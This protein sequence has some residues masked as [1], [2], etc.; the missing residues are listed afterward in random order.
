MRVSRSIHQQ[1]H[2]RW[3]HALGLVTGLIIISEFV[4]LGITP[5]AISIALL[6][7]GVASV[8]YLEAFVGPAE[9]GRIRK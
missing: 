5:L 3:A 1:F 8:I 2:R 4:L 9:Q 7:V 6:T